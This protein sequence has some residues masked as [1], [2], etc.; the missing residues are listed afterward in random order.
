MSSTP[1]VPFQQFVLPANLQP[2]D[3]MTI[4]LVYEHLLGS[5]GSLSL[6]LNPGELI[7]DF[8]LELEVQDHRAMDNIAVH[9]PVIGPVL[10]VQPHQT[11]FSWS[12]NLST[13]E[14]SDNFGQHGF[15]G[16]LV[17]NIAFLPQSPKDQVHLIIFSSREVRKL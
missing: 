15:N 5:E 7:D 13:V 4:T 12:Y 2:L 16:D 3:E 17:I 9:F 11:F 10:E 14:Q 1:G 8:R 6:S